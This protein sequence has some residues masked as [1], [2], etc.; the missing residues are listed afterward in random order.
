MIRFDDGIVLWKVKEWIG[1]QA[2]M[3][4]KVSRKKSINC[5]NV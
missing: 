3:M 4:Y 2:W 5:W 1:V